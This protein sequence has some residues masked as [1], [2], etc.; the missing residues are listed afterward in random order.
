MNSIQRHSS[1]V[2]MMLAA[3]TLL[4]SFTVLNI[5]PG[6]I[7][8]GRI[9]RG[10]AAFA[11]NNASG[12]NT[13]EE[14]ILFRIRLPRIALGYIVGAGL[15]CVGAS[16]QSLLA[17][18]LADPYI[19]GASSG[20][21]LG[22]AVV[23]AC[24]ARNGALQPVGAFVGALIAI[25]IVYLLARRRGVMR[26]ESLLLS[27]V[28]TNSFLFALVIYLLSSAG[29]DSGQILTW[30]LGSLVSFHPG[31]IAG[32]GVFTAIG[33]GI[34]QIY[35]WRLNIIALGEEKARTLGVNT[36]RTKLI[37]FIAGSLIVGAVVSLSGLVGFVGLIVPHI[38][39]FLVGPDNRRIIIGSLFVGGNFVVIADC[40]ARTAVQPM[41]LPLGVITA[42]V[43]APFFL[44]LM[45]KA[46]TS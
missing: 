29:R 11:T 20:A 10:V 25:G 9:A 13:R 15:A 41:E 5:G 32:A 23:I 1:V 7:P 18:P 26:V 38:V 33:I 46:R 14:T 30:L 2:F 43:G 6:R 31:L 34:L 22:V 37:V 19:L 17:N 40:V 35:A 4:I 24:G 27:G 44:Y 45:R 42:L 16:F 8:P 3:A 21:A 28:I 12:L 36:E 39:R